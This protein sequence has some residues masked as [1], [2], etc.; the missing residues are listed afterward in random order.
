MPKDEKRQARLEQLRSQRSARTVTA[1]D[2][3]VSLA[4][5]YESVNSEFLLEMMQRLLRMAARKTSVEGKTG[6][7]WV[8]GSSVYGNMAVQDLGTS[9]NIEAKVVSGKI[10]I[11]I[12]GQKG[13][14]QKFSFSLMET[15]SGIAISRAGMA[16]HQILLGT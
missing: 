4:A 10:Q 9:L 13:P 15:P 8:S 1:M 14:R 6:S 5:Q 11:L 12:E 16:A 2:G 3:N 7:W